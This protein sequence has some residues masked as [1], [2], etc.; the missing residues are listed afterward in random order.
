MDEQFLMANRKESR[1]YFHLYRE[2]RV[3]F[4][5]C[6]QSFSGFIVDRSREGLGVVV[7]DEDREI[8]PGDIISAMYIDKP[9]MEYC[10]E[11]LKIVY[12]KRDDISRKVNV[13]VMVADDEQINQLDRV[14]KK[15]MEAKKPAKKRKAAST[16][17][18][19][20]SKP[21]RLPASRMENHY[22]DEAV[23]SRLE[24]IKEHYGINARFLKSNRLYQD[25]VVGHIENYIGT[26]EVPVGIAGPI[27]VKGTYTDGYVAVPIA[28]SEGALVSSI[29]RGAKACSM[30][31][32]IRVH[33]TR[34]HMIRAPMFVCENMDGAINLQKWIEQHQ[35]KIV[36]KAESVSS[37]ARLTR[38][39]SVLFNNAL[40]IKF[41]YD[42][43]DAS[44]Q[45]MT[46]ACTFFACEW[47]ETKIKNDPS[48]KYSYYRIEGN[49]SGDKKINYQNFITGRGVG[50]VADAFVKEN[51]LRRLLR[52]KPEEIVE[53]WRHAEVAAS[54]IGMFGAN[55]NFANVVAGIFTATGQDIA[56]VHESAG[57]ILKVNQEEGGVRISA[58]L[59]SLVIG[60]V[61]GGTNLPSQR[62]CLDIMGCYGN[63]RVFR[64]AEI[65]AAACLSL[66]LST[67]AAIASGDFVHAHEKLGR[68][69]PK[70]TLARSEVNKRFFN[71]MVYDKECKV[72]SA[73]KKVID[74]SA[75]VTSSILNKRRV[76][77]TGIFKYTLSFEKGK[78][79]WSEPL[80][81]KLKSSDTE[82]VEIGINI[83]R[84]SGE[85]RLPGLFEA[86][87][88]VFGYDRSCVREILM[89][90]QADD[91]VKRYFPRL[92]GSMINEDRGIYSVLMEDF[93]DQPML[94]KVDDI[95]EWTEPRIRKVLS[96]LAEI[97]SIYLDNYETLMEAVPL[98]KYN[99]DTIYQCRHL[100]RELTKYNY[101]RHTDI[102]SKELQKILN[103]YLRKLYDHTEGMQRFPMTLSHNDSNPRNILFRRYKDGDFPIMY[104]WE[105]SLI[106]NPQHDLVEFLVFVLPRD[107]FTDNFNK[108]AEFYLDELNRISGLKFGKTEFFGVLLMNALDL[109]AVRF[110]LYLLVHNINRFGFLGRVYA[111]LAHLI[112]SRYR[113]VFG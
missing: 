65:I 72:V 30:C 7:P 11:G 51:V 94:N 19:K 110:N 67:M 38:L 25:R 26:V 10:V 92:Y 64:L 76:G 21:D 58:F 60:T 66:D 68:N 109:A 71:K 89:Y 27:L 22:G 44:G 82:M 78:R 88:D 70:K 93:S 2:P 40:H 108:Y 16:P 5:I 112:T 12:S 97:H 104:D 24:W 43:G 101:S 49:F 34:Q 111:N 59:P 86:Y 37:V 103:K 99:P 42:T 35:T 8:Q 53:G 105:L 45:N 9:E 84:L 102:V 14:F 32:G 15:L 17:Q 80:V 95:S 48:I 47:I 81:L 96:T 100:L 55:I 87:H 98:K 1:T 23:K 77:Y 69:R 39:E 31:G 74:A 29:T 4:F 52:V 46:S 36:K 107:N 85:D 20:P 90:E 113:Y 79:S 106:Q 91:R 54:Q 13:G 3:L 57:G 75:G 18:Q 61:G 63:G 28:T 41:F 33:V 56:C 50:V 83:A 73:R 6:D 62:E